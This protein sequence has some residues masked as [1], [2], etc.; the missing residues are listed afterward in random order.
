MKS[1]IKLTFLI[2]FAM[3][4]CSSTSC[5]R[6]DDDNVSPI[7]ISPISSDFLYCEESDF[8]SKNINNLDEGEA[9]IQAMCV[10]TPN[11]DG[12]NDIFLV[13]NLHKY[14]NASV[15]LLGNNGEVIYKGIE[16]EEGMSV[17][18]FPTGTYIY[19]I[20]VEN[21][22]TFVEYGYVCVAHEINSFDFS[23]ISHDLDSEEIYNPNDP[24]F[25]HN[26]K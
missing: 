10:V 4:I 21:E 13:K 16:I 8:E 12:V 5:K 15:T 22:Q 1:N 24:V 6:N 7:T 9:K 2:I 14:E 26:H 23:K 3:I 11:W 18:D 17:K 20:V 25:K 19:K